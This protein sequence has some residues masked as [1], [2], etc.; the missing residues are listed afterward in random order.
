MLERMKWA[1]LGIL[2]LSFIGLADNFYLAAH[3]TSGTPLVCNI[4]HLTDCNVVANSPY[5]RVFGI[6]VA[7]IGVSLFSL[8]LGA[9]ILELLFCTYRIRRGIQVLAGA[10][11]LLS[12]ISVVIQVFVIHALCIYCLL[13]SALG[14]GVFLLAL[15]LEPLLVK[16]SSQDAKILT[17]PPQ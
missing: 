6:P 4:E 12:L 11:L 16:R 17:M 2:V 8:L 13:S 10:E 9:T 5:S 1:L 7:Y 14:L 3:E 15:T